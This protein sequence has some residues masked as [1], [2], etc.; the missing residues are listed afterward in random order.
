[1][2]G[3]GLT[4]PSP[5]TH[6]HTHTHTCTHA[7]THART[8]THTHTLWA[9]CLCLFENKKGQDYNSIEVRDRQS[10]GGAKPAR[11]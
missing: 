11:Q 9:V 7:R 8:H 10:V 6:T 5:H 3:N 2:A 1:M 4:P